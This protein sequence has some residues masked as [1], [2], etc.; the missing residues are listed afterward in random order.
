MTSSPMTPREEMTVR[1]PL[2][3]RV[4]D[5]LVLDAGTCEDLAMPHGQ[6]RLIRPPV[7]TLFHQVLAYLRAKSDPPKRPYGSMAGREGVAA[8]PR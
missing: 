3:V 2:R 1:Y 6:E 7:T 8:P 4:N 5:E